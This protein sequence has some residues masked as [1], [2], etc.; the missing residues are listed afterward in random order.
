M[1]Q[2]RKL[3]AWIGSILFHAVLVLC[4]LHLFVPSPDKGTPWERTAIGTIVASQPSGGAKVSEAASEQESKTDN[5]A[6]ENE[7]FSTIKLNSLPPILALGQNQPNAPSTGVA[8][9]NEIAGSFGS[10]GNTAGNGIGQGDT[11]VQL[12]GRKGRGTKF[13][14]V[15]DRSGSMEGA[16]LRRA[17]EELIRSFDALDSLHQFNIIFYNHEFEMWRS[18]GGRKLVFA[19]PAEKKNAERFIDSITAVGGTGHY[20][21]LMEAIRHRPDVIFFLTDGDA[22][23]DLKPHELAAIDRENS[24]GKGVQI[25]VIH[26]GSGGLTD[27]ESRFLRQLAEQNYGEYEYINVSGW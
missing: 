19:T 24:F 23:D 17:K 9:A 13:M 20:K 14:F 7:T 1:T 10:S 18:G 16:P 21:P 27:S 5:T 22:K 8:S 6:I 12:F 15:F 25:N 3:S 11:E 4:I 2:N 26:F